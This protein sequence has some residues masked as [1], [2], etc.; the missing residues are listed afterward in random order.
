MHGA[1]DKMHGLL[2]DLLELSR[3]GRVEENPETLS[4]T[5]LAEA[6]RDLVLGAIDRERATVR[7]LP[8]DLT[9]RGNR[10]RLL[11]IWQNLIDNA[12]KYRHPER[13][14]K[15]EIG[16][17]TT[18]EGPIF[19]VSDN[20]RG[21]DPRY[22][23]KIFGL[24]N[25]LDPSAPGSGLGL[26]LIKRIVELYKGRIWVESEEGGAGSRFHFTLPEACNQ[27]EEESE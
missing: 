27:H 26:A 2:S 10:A 23:E 14:P 12:V 15:I 22:Q 13:E 17:E 24:F 9:L 20:G 11:E 16:V 4:F 18:A 7:I 19:F 1:A 3:V 6:A 25:Q 8:S 21:I 5:E